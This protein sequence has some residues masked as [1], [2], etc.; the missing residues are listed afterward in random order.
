MPNFPTITSKL[1]SVKTGGKL[2]QVS[3]LKAMY[4]AA[5]N[6]VVVAATSPNA[7]A[8]RTW[9]G[10]SGQTDSTTINQR[11]VKM[12]DYMNGGL[13]KI[14]F[15][16]CGVAGSIAAFNQY[17]HL[18]V[19]GG[20]DPSKLNKAS[21]VMINLGFH[22]DRYSWGEKVGALVHEITHM[23]I[24]TADVK[25]GSDEI[26]GA[27]KCVDLAGSHSSLAL[28]NADNWCY[29]FTSYHGSILQRGEDWRFLTPA[30]VKKR[31]ATPIT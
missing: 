1:S 7:D 3:V 23:C 29:Y 28:K 19:T 5:Y 26:Y 11:A 8:K 16:C 12:R 6:L 14:T 9:F 20:P 4:E 30:E 21:T 18:K 15:S 27:D 2:V 17:S 31:R 22:M 24:G 10:S 25:L 13:K